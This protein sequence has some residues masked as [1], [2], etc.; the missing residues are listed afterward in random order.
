M[1]GVLQLELSVCVSFIKRQFK[2]LNTKGE[3]SK[4]SISLYPLTAQPLFHSLTHSG[5]KHNVFAFMST[6]QIQF[7]THRK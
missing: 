7:T 5:T 6:Q 4:Q 3:K 2:T 1:E